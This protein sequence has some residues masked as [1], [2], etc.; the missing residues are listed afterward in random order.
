MRKLICATAVGLCTV[1]VMAAPLGNH[2]LA[3]AS[4]AS[5]GRTAASVPDLPL[6]PTQLE[7]SLAIPGYGKHGNDPNINPINLPGLGSINFDANNPGKGNGT[8]KYSEEIDIDPSSSKTPTRLSADYTI[9]EGSHQLTATYRYS[10]AGV[11]KGSNPDIKP[12]TLP[13]LGTLNAD[14]A[15]GGKGDNLSATLV[16]TSPKPK[17]SN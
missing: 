12:V 9:P 15:N 4:T 2:A 17:G 7:T 14:F 10:S 8:A 13:G 3:H 1:P 11:G 6:P 16:Y 5:A